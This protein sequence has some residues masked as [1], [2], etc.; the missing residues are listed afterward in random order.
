MASNKRVFWTRILGALV[1]IA[2]IAGFAMGVT[3]VN[4]VAP[5]Y[6]SEVH[7]LGEPVALKGSF[8]EY[9]YEHTD[10]YEITV[11]GASRMSVNEYISR[12]APDSSLRAP[13]YNYIASDTTDFDQVNLV[14]LDIVIRNDGTGGEESGYL[15]SLGWSLL[16]EAQRHLWL[17]VDSELFNLSVS[18]IEGAFQLSVKPGTEFTVH[19]PFSTTERDGFLAPRGN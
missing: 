9:E 18:Q 11:T 13:D 14:V 5:T 4:R 8:A 1:G 12:F 10:P 15:D 3:W 6:P 2:L 19:V 7:S 16:S 17:R